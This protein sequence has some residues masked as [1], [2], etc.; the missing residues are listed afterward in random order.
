MSMHY[1]FRCFFVSLF[2]FSYFF[3]SS[4]IVQIVF[5]QL[6]WLRNIHF[7]IALFFTKA[8]MPVTIL[9]LLYMWAF[10]LVGIF[11]YGHFSLW[12]FF[13]VGIFPCGH[14][15]CGLFC[16][17]FSCGLLSGNRCPHISRG[18]VCWTYWVAEMV[19]HRVVG[20]M[21]VW[22]ACEVVSSAYGVTVGL[23][24]W[25]VAGAELGKCSPIWPGQELFGR[26]HWWVTIPK[27][28]VRCPRP[29]DLPNHPSS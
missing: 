23:E 20:V 22:A 5:F 13:L 6:F 12:A 25:A 15:S 18:Q 29:D 14:F 17:L 3:V 26:A 1:R 10:F 8:L 19:D 9:K 11:P 27:H 24:P 28:F 21:S 16:V 7:R 2:T 4:V